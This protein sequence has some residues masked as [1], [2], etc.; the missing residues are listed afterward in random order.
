[1]SLQN[2][3]VC[4]RTAVNIDIDMLAELSE[5]LDLVI[6]V[7]FESSRYERRRQPRT[8]E[9]SDEHALGY[10]RGFDFETF[11]FQRNN[12]FNDAGPKASRS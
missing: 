7:D 1:M 12:P 5:Q 10:I 3:F 9:L 4:Q 6:G 11:L 2:F 8:I